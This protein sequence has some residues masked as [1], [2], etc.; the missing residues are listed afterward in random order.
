MSTPS[1]YLHEEVSPEERPHLADKWV[2]VGIDLAPND[3]LE[4]GMAA[5]DRTRQLLRMDKLNTDEQILIFL[6]GLGPPRNVVVALDVPK[7]L[8]IPGKWRQEEIKMFPLRLTKQTSGEFTDRCSERAWKLYDAIKSRGFVVFLYFNHLA[9]TRY[10]LFIP[11]R[12]RT[13]RGCRALQATIR[14]TLELGNMPSNLAPSSVLDAMI[15]AYTAW[16]SYWGT[17]G[18]TYR[19]FWDHHRRLMLEPLKRVAHKSGRS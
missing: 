18:E 17:H 15:G 8:S 19:F 11:F 9:K 7:S 6:E 2:F 10:D 3:M 14:Q 1:V 13:P 5:V 12:T 4:T 16:T